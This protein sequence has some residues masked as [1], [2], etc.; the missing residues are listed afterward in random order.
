MDHC[1]PGKKVVWSGS[2][3]GI[4]AVHEFFFEQNENGVKLT[5]IEHFKGPMLLAARLMFLPSRLHN[6]TIRL[7]DA[8]KEK[9][10]EASSET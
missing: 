10:E 9:A 8:I 6:L 4:H 7:L 2:K 3:F 5:S 1:E